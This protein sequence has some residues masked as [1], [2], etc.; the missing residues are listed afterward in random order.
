[1]EKPISLPV[2]QLA[3]ILPK[4][5]QTAIGNDQRFA[6][7]DLVP[8]IFPGHGGI[9]GLVMPDATASPSAVAAANEIARKVTSATELSANAAVLVQGDHIIF[10]FYPID[11]D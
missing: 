1:V 11:R 7:A 5:L 4:A 9:I 8:Q 6:N 3:D 2:S 10:G